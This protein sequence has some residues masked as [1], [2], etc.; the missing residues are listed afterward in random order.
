MI[1]QVEKE[2]QC[3]FDKCY[4][5]IVENFKALLMSPHEQTSG[6]QRSIWTLSKCLYSFERNLNL[7]QTN[8]AKSKEVVIGSVT[9]LEPRG[10]KMVFKHCLAI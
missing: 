7:F 9:E 2:E 8:H 4:S 10:G 3:T 5:D 6:R 1:S